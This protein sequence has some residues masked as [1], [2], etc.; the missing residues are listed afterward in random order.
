ME[1]KMAEVAALYG[2]TIDE[3]FVVHSYIHRINSKVRFSLDGMQYYDE[4]CDGWY[5]TE[6]FLRQLLTGRAVIVDGE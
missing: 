4:Q 1:N 2:K 6:G 5:N 3:P